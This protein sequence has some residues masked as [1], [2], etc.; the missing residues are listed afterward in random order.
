VDK[1]EIDPLITLA[2]LKLVDGTLNLKGARRNTKIML[3]GEG[4]LFSESV[5]NL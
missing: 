1:K 5:T 4:T 3:R 2:G